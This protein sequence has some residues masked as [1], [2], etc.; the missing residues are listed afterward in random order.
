MNRSIKS[1]LFAS[2]IAAAVGCLVMTASGA[3]ATQ[4][5]TGAIFTSTADGT[6]VNGNIYDHCCDVFLNGGPGLH[7]KCDAAGLPD[8]DYYF[9][10][11]DPSGATLLSSDDIEQ[12]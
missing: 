1:R 4:P 12:R 10:V 3:F 8:G 11:T 6:T 7:A 2:S 9:Q 5:V